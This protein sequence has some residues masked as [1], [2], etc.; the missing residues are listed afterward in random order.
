MARP[1]STVNRPR[2]TGSSRRVARFSGRTRRPSPLRPLAVGAVVVVLALFAG[3]ALL[4]SSWLSA[5]QV[6]VAGERTLTDEQVIATANVDSSAP[7]LTLDLQGVEDRVSALRRVASASVH[8]IW[9]HTV[10]ITVTERRPVATM[11]TAG[12]RW[13]MLDTT[14]LLFRQARTQPALPVVEGPPA[15][16]RA[17]LA[18]TATV[19]EALPPQLLRSVRVVHAASMDSITLQLRDGRVVRWGSSED[20]AEKVRVVSVLL[21][22]RAHRYDVS[23]PAQP[24]TAG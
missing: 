3:W 9:P 21:D 18:A 10:E 17:T 24:T 16:D 22:Q 15:N 12:N 11:R 8:R 23:V 6:T 1:A 7:M 4:A 13:G 2:P 19:V 20:S 5:Q 14:G